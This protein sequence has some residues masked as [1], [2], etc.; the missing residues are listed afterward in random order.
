VLIPELCGP[1]TYKTKVVVQKEL[2]NLIRRLLASVCLQ[3]QLEVPYRCPWVR[4]IVIRSRASGLFSFLSTDS[5]ISLGEGD[6]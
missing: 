6:P 2:G 5:F 4:V 1:P 3:L